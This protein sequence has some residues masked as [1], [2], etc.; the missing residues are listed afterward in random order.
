MPVAKAKVGSEQLISAFFPAD[1]VAR[2]VQ[3]GPTEIHI[4]VEPVAEAFPAD[5]IPVDRAGPW[6]IPQS[7]VSFCARREL[8]QA[9]ETALAAIRE[10]FPTLVALQFFAESE[11][12][13]ETV[14]GIRVIATGEREAIGQ[15][16]WACLDRW[17]QRLKPEEL[18]RLVLDQLMA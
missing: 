2:V 7:V 5:P 13:P 3:A 15:A 6:E 11:G 18:S 1:L 12:R 16:Y 9:L 10:T 8:S 14:L 4:R 17:A